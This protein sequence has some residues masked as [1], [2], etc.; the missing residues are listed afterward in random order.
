V[1][2]GAA[3]LA[4]VVASV[5][6]RIKPSLVKGW[7]LVLHERHAVGNLQQT[8]SDNVNGRHNL[9]KGLGVNIISQLKRVDDVVL[10]GRNSRSAA[11]GSGQPNRCTQSIPGSAQR[12]RRGIDERQKPSELT[13]CERATNSGG[14]QLHN[15]TALSTG[16]RQDEV[17]LIEHLL[18]Q[19]PSSKRF[20]RNAASPQQ[21]G[22][23]LRD[24][25]PDQGVSASRTHTHRGSE[26]L[27]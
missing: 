20:G 5:P 7:R 23:R 19:T 16:Q 17:G 18:R 2:L 9:A 11:F 25:M 15:Q 26:S 1:W 12:E 22:H 27:G 24:G 14:P 3:A 13:Q 21:R 10:D 4:L 6:L 8:G